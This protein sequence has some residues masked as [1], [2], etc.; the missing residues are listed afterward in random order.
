MK[1]L[2]VIFLMFGVLVFSGCA[3]RGQNNM[4]LPEANNDKTYA[5]IGGG[6]GAHQGDGYTLA[7]PKEGYRYEI[8]YEDGNLEEAW[9]YTKKDAVEIKVTT[10]KNSDSI[11]ARGRFLMDNDD[12]IFED[13]TGESICGVEPDGDT[14]WFRMHEANGTTYIISWEYPKNTNEDLKKELSDIANTFELVQ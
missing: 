9:D 4:Y 5:E 11:S 1:R 8:D 14:L 2:T 12:Y 10:Y 13:M 7:V 3:D 6:D